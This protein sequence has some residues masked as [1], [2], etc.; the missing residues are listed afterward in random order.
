MTSDSSCDRLPKKNRQSQQ[1]TWKI[2]IVMEEQAVTTHVMSIFKMAAVNH[3]V[4]ALG[5]MADQVIFVV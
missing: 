4:F 3:V 5:V 1:R 2:E